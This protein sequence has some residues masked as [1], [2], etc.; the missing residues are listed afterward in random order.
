MEQS[1]KSV[2]RTQRQVRNKA[3]LYQQALPAV[4][5]LPPPLPPIT[6]MSRHPSPGPSHSLSVPQPPRQ[7]QSKSYP[8][9]I[10]AGAED[11]KYQAKYKE[12]KRTVKEIEAVRPFFPKL[13]QPF[14]SPVA[15][16]IIRPC[17]TMT[18]SIIKFF[19]P[20]AVFNV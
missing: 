18:N 2:W 16:N 3:R 11:V 20:N 14:S 5:L 17:R 8:T 12:L 13:L 7:K 15:F 19:T 6:T 9:G 4:G 10:A 1:E